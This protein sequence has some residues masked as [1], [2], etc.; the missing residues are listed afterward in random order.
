MKIS[1]QKKELIFTD[2]SFYII[3]IIG[4]LHQNIIC[5]IERSRDLNNFSTSL[6]VTVCL[7]KICVKILSHNILDSVLN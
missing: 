7:N 6:E 3:V 2:S 4:I 5:Q 1:K